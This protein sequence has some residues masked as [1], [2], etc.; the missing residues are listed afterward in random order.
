[1][2]VEQQELRFGY[3]RPPDFD[4]PP[5]AEAQR[6]DGAVGDRLEA[7]QLEHGLRPLVFVAVGTAHEEHVLPERAATVTHPLGH[8]EVLPGRHTREEF[9]PLER[10]ADAEAR[11]LVCRYP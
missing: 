10:A 2:L 8:E 3:Q 9:D 11:T 1:R 5:D 4:E 6:L 7:E